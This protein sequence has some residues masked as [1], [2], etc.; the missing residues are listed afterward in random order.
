M[1]GLVLAAPQSG[2]GK[3][4]L[5]QAL[6]RLLVQQGFDVL[7]AKVGPDYIDPQFLSLAAKQPC[8]NLDPWAMRQ[9]SR[10][11]LLELTR[12]SHSLLIIEGVMGL[13]DGAADG[14]GSTADLARELELPV[15]LVVN[16]A[17]QSFS[18]AALVQGF[19]RFRPEITIAGVI[20]NNVGSARHETMLR[21][22]LA[23][24][25][26][27]VII[28]GAIPR[29]EVFILPERHLGLV[30]AAEL[31]DH[32][33]KQNIMAEKLSEYLDI[34]ALI[35][36]SRPVA[37]HP[38]HNGLLPL[39]VQRLAVAKDHA[40]SFL[41]SGQIQAW[42]QQG[43]EISLFSPLNDEAPD[44]SAEAIFLC[45]GY[46]EL[47]AK[48]ISCAENFRAAL[49]KAAQSNIPIHGECGGYMV[50]GQYLIDQG[51]TRHEMLGLLP[52]GFRLLHQ[53]R[54]LGYR[55]AT[56]MDDHLFGV[57]GTRYKGHEFHYGTPEACAENTQPLFNTFDACGN[58]CAETGMR[59]RSVSGSFVHI[60]DYISEKED[61][62]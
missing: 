34:Q 42:R 18:L 23:Q 55:Q 59:R 29:H 39:A 28:F 41:Y 4:V 45:G 43:H 22:A 6:I 60:I 2:S 20:L 13:F 47:C 11:M 35:A 46:P 52:V 31:H 57:K 40:F 15:I 27:E 25:C 49:H 1:R 12:K 7:P 14:T 53:K 16:A 10:E 56:L 51:G 32:E 24:H 30:Q 44:P 62:L 9:Q 26:P 3:T 5:S 19:C 58:S 54:A 50:L 37:E 38:T 33:G 8:I 61:L 21:A 36:A 48:Q 17:K